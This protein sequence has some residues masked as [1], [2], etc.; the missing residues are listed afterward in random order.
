MDE[1]VV[2]H[3]GI[4]FAE[5]FEK[6]VN[7]ALA[8]LPK[9]GQIVG[10]QVVLAYVTPTMDPKAVEACGSAISRAGYPPD[11]LARLFALYCEARWKGWA[12]DAQDGRRAALPGGTRGVRRR[13]RRTPT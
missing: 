5:A 12:T 4:N 2:R 3:T 6:A 13:P 1:N 8:N 11:E 10:I 7:G 9:G